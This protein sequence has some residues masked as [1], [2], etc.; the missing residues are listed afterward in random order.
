MT[1]RLDNFLEGVTEL[2]E[3]YTHSLLQGEDT[4]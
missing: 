3:S 2:T 4:G 1:L